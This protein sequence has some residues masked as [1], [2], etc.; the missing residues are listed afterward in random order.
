MDPRTSPR[1]SPEDFQLAHSSG[2][3]TLTSAIDLSGTPAGIA[4]S[5]PSSP[6][7]L[8]TRE[9]SISRRR[10]SW[11]RM[12]R[13]HVDILNDPLRLDTTAVA[14]V[15]ST[16][17][18]VDPFESG[19]PQEGDPF[20]RERFFM[21]RSSSGANASEASLIPTHRPKSV[22]SSEY[23]DIDLD[24]DEMRLTSFPSGS[25]GRNLD[26]GGISGLDLERTPDSRRSRRRST[27]RYSVT[28][29]P[30]ERLRSVKRNLRRVSL[31]VVNL[32]GAG[33]EEKARGRSIRL[34]DE[35]GDRE[36]TRP[37][38]KERARMDGKEEMEDEDEEEEELP[39]LGTRIPIRGRALGFLGPTSRIRL[40]MFRFLTY[41]WTEPVILLLILFNAIVLT[42][43]AARSFTL[44]DATDDDQNPLPA[45]VRGY[46]H[47]WE[48]YT[49]FALFII[50]TLEAF[51]RIVTSGFLLDPE[52]P[53]SALHRNMFAGLS[54]VAPLQP[55]AGDIV[56]HSNSFASGVT[57]SASQHAVS[58]PKL[59][60]VLSQLRTNVTAPFALAHHKAPAA[61]AP[62]QGA[63]RQRSASLLQEK[64]N[65]S[66]SDMAMS[67][68][69]EGGMPPPHHMHDPRGAS[70]PT[71]FSRALRSAATEDAS[72]GEGK[73]TQEYI[74]LPFRLSV[75]TAQDHV[76]RGVPYLRHSWTRLDCVA[77]LAFWIAFALAQTG[78]ERSASRHIAVFRALSVLRTSRLLAVTSGTTTIMRSLK[79]A[80]PLLTNVAYFV[81]FAM[82]L[83]SIIGIQSF[84]GSYR[85]SCF[86]E[87][88]LGESEIQLS[89][90]CG[91][92]IDPTS[93]NVTGYVMND[94]TIASS[95]KGY[96]CPLGQLCK[97]ADNPNSNIQSFD[98][99]YFAAL[100]VV[101][102]ASANGWSPVMYNMIDAEYFVSCTFFIVCI[103]V[104][105]FWL[106][107][108]FVAV[109]T[110][111]FSAIRKDTQKSAFGAAPLGSVT[112]EH[113]DDYIISERSGS[114]TSA[115]RRWYERTKWIWV[116]FALTSVVLQ[117][118]RSADSSPE[119]LDILEWGELALT[120]LF[121]I[122][123]SWR[124]LAYL[125]LWRTFFDHGNNWLDLLL[126]VGSTVIQIPEIRNS[127]IY[128]WLTIF[129]L[130]R[131]YRVILEVPRMRPLLLAVFGNLY[132]L[133]NMSLFLLLANYIGALVAAQLLRGDMSSSETMNFKEIYNSFLAMYQ[134]FSSENWTTVLFDASVAEVPL[135]QSALIA[136]FISVWF[137]FANFI[138]LQLFIAVI[139]ENFDVAEELKR[140]KQATNYLAMQQPIQ[141]SPP[142]LRRLNPY[143]WFR[144][145][146]KS[147]A[148]ENLPSNLILP[149][150]KAVIQE[151]AFN[152]DF[153]MSNSKRGKGLLRGH[154]SSK[155]ITAL[156]R[157]F[158][159]ESRS[160][161][162]PLATLRAGRRDSIGHQDPND[163]ELERHLEILATINADAQDTQDFNDVLYERRAQKA[164]FI[165]AHPS[166]DKTF[167][168][169]SQKSRLRQLCQ[170]LVQPAS[171]D[172]IFGI[173]H[174]PLWH[175]LFQLLLL[176]AVVGGIIVEAIA[177]PVYRRNFYKEHGEIRDS[178][179]DIAETTFGLMLFVEFLIKIVADGFAFTPNAYIRSIWN[180][181]DIFILTGILV[182][183][184]T[185]LIFI[186]GLSRFTRSLKALRALR[187][188][189]LIDK[190]RSTFQSLIISGALRIV[191][192]AMLAI[193]YMIPYAVWGLNIFHGLLNEC[194]DGSINGLSDCVNE[195][196]NNVLGDSNAFTFLVP[197]V[198]DNPAPSTT[199]SF[200]NFRSSLLILFEIVSLEG[201][202]DVMSVATSA[203]GQNLQPQTNNAEANSIFFLIYIQ[204]G[205]V[206][207]L[208]LF[209]SIIIGNFSSKTGLALLTKEQREWI[210]LQKLIKRQRPSKRP[211]R[212]PS[213]RFRAW[214]YDRAV[215][216]HGWW[217][218]MM[219][220]L[221]VVHILA[222]MTQTLST[223]NDVDELRNSW[224]LAITLI[225]VVDIVVRWFGLGFRSFKA[226]GWNIFDVVVAVG[227]LVTTVIIR[228]GSQSFL[229]AQLQK[230]FLVSIAFKLVQRT[231]SL[232]QLFKT[233]MA[234]LPVILSLLAL[235]FILFLFFGI[236]FVEV[237]SLTKWH[238]AET[239]TQNY[240]S[241][242]SALVMLAFMS[243]GE[244]WNEYMHDYALIYPK[245]TPSTETETDSDCGSTGWAFSLFIAWNLLSMY[246]F[247]NMFTGVVVE[248]FS[249]VFQLVGGTKTIT[250]EEMRA[251]K[252]VWAECANPRTGYLEK[253]QLVPFLGKLSGVFE[254][255]I[256]PAE[257]S[258]KNLLSSAQATDTDYSWVSASKV[259]DGVDTA[260]LSKLLGGLDS[261]AIRKRR[262]LYA[263]VY[264]EAMVSQ[265]PG[266]GIS[267]SNMLLLLAH[268][269]LIDDREALALKDLVTRT[270]INKFV[271]DLVNLDRVRSLLKT[272]YYRR[273]FRAIM[274]E[275]RRQQM[276]D[277]DIPAIVVED[278]PSTPFISTR[279][280][281]L[282]NRDSTHFGDSASPLSSPSPYH[283]PDFSFALESP[284]RRGRGLQRNRRVSDVSMLSTDLGY[285][286]P[287]EPSFTRDSHEEEDPQHV[288]SSMQ[289]SMWGEMMLEAAGEP[290][291]GY[292]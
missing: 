205:A 170:R 155:S 236:L 206:V 222:L 56:P 212:R 98:T 164:D 283:S 19:T 14:A 44:P 113:D 203:V 118:T 172:R 292:S 129:Q 69:L 87:P 248:S 264:N 187:L 33:L 174:S 108:L 105:N 266:K 180:W 32:A 1:L 13:Q 244:G 107:N 45:P 37:R 128:P 106:I 20:A 288:L 171:G 209:V 259:V 258:I 84:K 103:V 29:S 12:E 280:I 201:W 282:A 142:W 207:I 89:Q 123:I 278:M 112:D 137:L 117:S 263:R 133:V 8:A 285:Q 237:F 184:T 5:T 54:H 2:D 274:E 130:A 190:M 91:G 287:I 241:L 215:H 70:K 82:I 127:G 10:L 31:R 154:Y 136:L 254:V 181:L 276:L 35:E 226:N 238:S 200:D 256:Y 85:R 146:P 48:D 267:F 60:T 26:S 228:L 277:Q 252:K 279:D 148:V 4:S 269:K 220:L 50:F 134:I 121:D 245:C 290:E 135:G 110:N 161:D 115:I 272:I 41:S 104:L 24:D 18:D 214:C 64:T 78:T 152:P 270:E 243:T 51:A 58:K 225:Y 79:R 27:L 168:I 235:W 49:L 162:V 165:R 21:S 109:I 83:F 217:S 39:D 166:Y 223:Q 230:L 22:T 156:Q 153:S 93:L 273:Q 15:S 151:S 65:G 189:T 185:G 160:N 76:A 71:F 59:N 61:L 246:I 250:R 62:P 57:R 255:R 55:Y 158:S 139:N 239:R 195:Y 68:T 75:Y 194:N 53:V 210:D 271:N 52:V 126:A 38:G 211:K 47:T 42:V 94:G 63:T 179:F 90:I 116:L 163:E 124:F 88:T 247:V 192:A 102:V 249:Y 92:Y 66:A 275:K 86:L 218:R 234:S 229:I 186:G 30:G 67:I 251:F 46:F 242:G 73:H 183:V 177:T 231:N 284:S 97:E 157:L 119:H 81:L 72:G 25:S 173:P 7:S 99:I 100:E 96:I 43:Q 178:W 80:R 253:G 28:P 3:F 202:I 16:N 221:F 40:A 125:P 224:F 198:W 120:F 268:H 175:T 6:I 95:A 9:G 169:F 208:T 196:E 257:F 191:D 144:A 140:G 122:D 262:T 261:T 219:T 23:N 260:K 17:T 34:P 204:L 286:Y 159:G 216:K 240:S 199:F 227:A 188:I 138:L 193:L 167:W 111:T 101:I 176:L 145:N 281:T 289:N 291:H 143:R 114:G 197:R 233:A 131:F 147:I 36:R 132:G 149:M 150:Q 77:V 141:A 11:G 213:S 182:N 232:N 265:E 74:G